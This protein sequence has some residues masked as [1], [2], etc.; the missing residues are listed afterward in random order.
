VA[1]FRSTLDEALEASL[2]LYVVDASDPTHEAELEV[3]RSVLREIGADSVASRLVMNKTDR[4]DPPALEALRGKYPDAIFLS[5]HDAGDVATLRQTI[6]DFFEGEMEDAEIVLP[7][8][9]QRLIG[10][11][12]ENARVLAEEYDELGTRLRIR[13][14]PAAISRLRRALD[15]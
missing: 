3:T 4:L 2:L 5:A 7:Y 15:S 9:K 6:V 1:S 11:V 12:Y 10:E 14:L 13:G 8:A